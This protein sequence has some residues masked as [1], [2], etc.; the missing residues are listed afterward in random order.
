MPS[1]NIPSIGKGLI[2]PKSEVDYNEQNR[3]CW[4]FEEKGKNR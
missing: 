4:S 2:P 1:V 3:D